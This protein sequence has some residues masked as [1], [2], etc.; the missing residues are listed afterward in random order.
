V[1]GII[2][3]IER[4]IKEGDWIEVGQYSGFV[5]K[6]SVRST[7]IDTFDRA[8]VIVPNADLI[9]GTVVNWTLQSMNGRVKVPVGVS[10]DSDPEQVRELLLKIARDHPQTLAKPE[11]QVMFMG[12]GADSMDFELRAILRDVTLV[13]LAHSE[14]NFEIVRVFRENNIEIPFAQ[15]DVRI[16]NAED[17]LPKSKRV[18]KDRGAE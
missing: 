9:A 16:K 11:P 14:M 6:I 5:E 17:F 18:P 7:T 2:L 12:F 15:R 3:L 13:A 1:S 8:T 4:P 10:Y